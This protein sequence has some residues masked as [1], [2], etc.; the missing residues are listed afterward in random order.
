MLG[1]HF[2]KHLQ[3][4]VIAEMSQDMLFEVLQILESLA[5]EKL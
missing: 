1:R 3:N 4:K 5:P 2:P